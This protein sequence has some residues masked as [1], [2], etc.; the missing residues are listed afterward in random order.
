[1]QFIVHGSITADPQYVQACRS[2]IAEFRLE[3]RFKLAGNHNKPSNLYNIGDISMLSS[4]SEG[5]PYSVIEA[6]SCA[7]PVVATDVGGVR[8]ALQG[9]GLSVRPRDYEAFGSRRCALAPKVECIEMGQK[10]RQRVLDRFTLQNFV[11]QY[12]LSYQNIHT[13]AQQNKTRVAVDLAS[14]AIA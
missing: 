5:F 6:M 2:L 9:V 8:E 12:A 1:M 13:E 11:Q 7:R 3:N 10:A 14:A 4:I